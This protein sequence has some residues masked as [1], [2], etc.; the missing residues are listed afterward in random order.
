MR[1]AKKKKCLL[2]RQL[3][4]LVRPCYEVR[5]LENV[6]RQSEGS[7]NQKQRWCETYPDLQQAHPLQHAVELHLEHSMKPHPLLFP[8]C[9]PN[10][11]LEE[12][13][14][15]SNQVDKNQGSHLFDVQ[16]SHREPEVDLEL[17]PVAQINRRHQLQ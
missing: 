9:L 16:M 8:R 3:G 7:K 15:T 4:Q 10:S 2:N 12:M 5:G 6:K 11:L 1:R 14:M 17:H 13:E